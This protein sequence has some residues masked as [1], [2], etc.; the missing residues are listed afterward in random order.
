M[1]GVLAC[2][3]W[4]NWVKPG[5]SHSS[6]IS[7]IPKSMSVTYVGNNKIPLRVRRGPNGDVCSLWKVTW[8]LPGH[9]AD[10]HGLYKGCVCIFVFLCRTTGL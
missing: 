2:D 7:S 1:C 6:E 5:R 9:I 8:G 3:A 4:C 10:L